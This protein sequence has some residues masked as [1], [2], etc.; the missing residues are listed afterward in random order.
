[1]SNGNVAW[2]QT[3]PN[4][5]KSCYTDKDR[6]KLRQ[7]DRLHPAHPLKG[8]KCHQ[9]ILHQDKAKFKPDMGIR[10]SSSSGAPPKPVPVD[11]EFAPPPDSAYTSSFIY[12]C[13]KTASSSAS[14]LDAHLVQTYQRLPTGACD[15]QEHT[16]LTSAVPTVAP[17]SCAGMKRTA[18]NKVIRQPTASK[19]SGVESRRQ[20]ADGIQADCFQFLTQ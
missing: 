9:N 15:C 13:Q 6:A 1:M 12:E 8:C 20:K 10:G 14:T 19:L 3:S 5:H 11:S 16:A 2:L 17:A 4:D 18:R 7:K